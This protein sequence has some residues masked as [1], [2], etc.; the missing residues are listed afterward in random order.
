M[1]LSYA[2]IFAASI[3]M[4][5]DDA[6]PK[7]DF[8]ITKPI[9]VTKVTG[10]KDFEASTDNR[11]T[12]D[13]KLTIYYEPTNHIIEKTKDGYRA[14]FAQDGR[15]R[16]KGGKTAVWQKEKMFTYEAKNKIPPREIYLKTDMSLKSLPPGEY[17]LDLT[18]HD[19][20]AKPPALVMGTVAFEVIPAPAEKPAKDEVKK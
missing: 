6:P 12:P 19:G 13:D 10:Y 3:G 18:L 15:L 1:Q 5:P 11:L 14:L 9:I 16:K 8:R 2:L 20:L 17:E 4:P 7:S